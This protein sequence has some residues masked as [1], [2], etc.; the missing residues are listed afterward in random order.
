LSLHASDIQAAARTYLPDG[1]R[2]LLSIVPRG[3]RELAVH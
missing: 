2:V 3:K 1:A